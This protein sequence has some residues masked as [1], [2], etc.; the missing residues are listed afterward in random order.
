MSGI[1]A[2]IA[3]DRP[4]GCP[5]AAASEDGGPIDDVTW[6]ETADGTIEQFT[7]RGQ[8]ADEDHDEVFTYGQRTVNEFRRDGPEPCF[9]EVVETRFG[10]VADVQAREGTLRVTVHAGEVSSLRSLIADLSDRFSSVRLEYLVQTSD[11]ETGAVVP[12]DVDRLTDRQREVIA[13]AYRS[14]YFEYPRES[15]ATAVASELG[16]EPSTFSEHLAAAQSKLLG[17]VLEEA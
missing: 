2:E 12:V 17:D 13:T 15:N 4:P 10:P 9:C 16:I 7:V 5:V 11:D 6:A 1:R 3:V 14:G 8:A